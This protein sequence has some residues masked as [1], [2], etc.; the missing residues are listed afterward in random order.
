[1]SSGEAS[2]P[3]LSQ[4]SIGTYSN[5]ST[6]DFECPGPSQPKRSRGN[7]HVVD[8]KLVAVLETCKISD[9]KAVHLI[10]AIAQALNHD[11][12]SLIVNKTSIKRC[13]ETLREVRAQ[14]IKKTIQN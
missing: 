8:E 11:V 6:D 14:N 10:I 9:R 5:V 7:T 3:S 4:N 1:M 13:R 12:N 2:G